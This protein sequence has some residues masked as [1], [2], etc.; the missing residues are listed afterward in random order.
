MGLIQE[1]SIEDY[2]G[3]DYFIRY[4]V[5]HQSHIP[6]HGDLILLI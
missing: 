5:N 1:L 6:E 2:W 4:L 3:L